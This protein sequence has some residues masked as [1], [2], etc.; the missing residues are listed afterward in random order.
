MCIHLKS[1]KK[2]NT[3][4][5]EKGSVVQLLRE[6]LLEEVGFLGKGVLGIQVITSA[7][8]FPT[9]IMKIHFFSIATGED[10]CSK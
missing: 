3:V 4:S 5:S 2:C 8:T 7:R 1:V 10:T 9:R 6:V